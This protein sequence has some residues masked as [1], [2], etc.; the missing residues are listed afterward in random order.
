MQ[1]MRDNPT[2]QEI[3]ARL[4]KRKREIDEEIGMYPAPIPACDAQF[5]YLL[6][7]RARLTR[8]LGRLDV[9]ADQHFTD[10]DAAAWLG[11]FLSAATYLE[12][13]AWQQHR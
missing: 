12:D 5:N 4:D 2:W 13:V 1:P 3:V 8:D 9:V 10:S 6:E 11:E 7:Q